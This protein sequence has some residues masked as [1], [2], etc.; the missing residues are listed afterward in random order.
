[1]TEEAHPSSDEEQSGKSRLLNSN[2][3][4]GAVGALLGSLGAVISGLLSFHAAVM[5]TSAEAERGRQSFFLTE[6]VAVYSTL[7]REAQAFQLSAS[8]YH[9][10]AQSSGAAT[11][12]AGTAL[13]EALANYE[14]AVAASWQVEVIATEIVQEAKQQ[15]AAELDKAR[16]LLTTKSEEAASYF[17]D[18]DQLMTGHTTRFANAAA[19]ELEGG[20]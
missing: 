19:A 5:A 11:V 2:G 18:L 16:E 12:E 8:R 6:R 1:M 17:R 10:L 20:R 15:L 14:D 9:D 7:L 13:E 4:W 3:F